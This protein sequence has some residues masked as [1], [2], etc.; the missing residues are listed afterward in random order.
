MTGLNEMLCLECRMLSQPH[1]Q[2]GGWGAVP[3]S[4]SPR[5]A[6]GQEG[7]WARLSEGAYFVG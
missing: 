5:R 4:E 3:K 7:V 1:T 6:A 2:L